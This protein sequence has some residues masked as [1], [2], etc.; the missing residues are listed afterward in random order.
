M[1]PHVFPR[2]DRFRTVEAWIFDLD[3]TLYPA[4]CDLF[5][6]IDARIG[7][8]L[9]DMLKLDATAARVVQKDY[10]RRYG[11]TLRGLMIEHGLPPEA[12]LDYVHDIDH[13]PLSPAP[14]LAE[15]LKALPGRRFIMTNGSQ[16]HAER[17]CERLGLDG[18]FDDIFDIA[19]AGHLPKPEAEAY[20]LFWA[21]SAIRPAEAAM[22]EDLPR[23]LKVPHQHGM[24][25]VLVVPRDTAAVVRE[26][27]EHEGRDDPHVDHVTDD[28]A[29]FLGAVVRA[30]APR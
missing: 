13:S 22:F 7:A 24:S 10:Y 23:N 25:T 29:R 3:N 2:L 8:F 21:R 14:R 12:F 16:R 15:A 11:T 5:S 6:Q 26:N 27:W 4:E 18:L 9:Q 30:I 28:L 19:A 1:S 20:D 17:V